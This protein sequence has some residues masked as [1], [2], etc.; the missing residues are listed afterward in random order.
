[1]TK[2]RY[3]GIQVG[4]DSL[5]DKEIKEGWQFCLEWDD[6]L[7][8]PSWP[9]ADVCGCEVKDFIPLQGI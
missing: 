1:M 5:S 2:Q 4:K 9:E 3:Y 7:C 8:H 6:M